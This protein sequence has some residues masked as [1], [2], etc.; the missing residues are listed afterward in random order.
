MESGL[1]IRCSESMWF[2]NT[3]PDCFLR[4]SHDPIG[5]APSGSKFGRGRWSWTF[6]R[7]WTESALRRLPHGESC[8]AHLRRRCCET[9]PTRP[10]W[11]LVSNVT[12]ARVQVI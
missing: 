2:P 5:T 6:V 4:R 9:T 11:K 1:R 8:G 12:E 7:D 3:Q 10:L